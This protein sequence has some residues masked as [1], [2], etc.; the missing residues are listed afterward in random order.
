MQQNTRTHSHPHDTRTQPNTL[1]HTQ[2][3][4]LKPSSASPAAV[5]SS[6]EHAVV[7]DKPGPLSWAAV[8]AWRDDNHIDVQGEGTNLLR[9]MPSLEDGVSGLFLM[10]FMYEPCYVFQSIC[11]RI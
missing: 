10:E 5:L 9:P 4:D 3:D 1:L 8:K 7:T 11:L 6:S 2:S